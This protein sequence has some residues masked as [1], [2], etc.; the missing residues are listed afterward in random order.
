M[1]FHRS[2]AASVEKLGQREAG[3]R[4]LHSDLPSYVQSVPR[5]SRREKT[6][7]CHPHPITLSCPWAAVALL[8]NESHSSS[9]CGQHCRNVSDRKE[10]LGRGGVGEKR[11]GKAWREGRGLH[12]CIK[13][14][15][16]LNTM[17]APGR[18]LELKGRQNKT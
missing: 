13:G 7:P 5:D 18:D 2:Q 12:R 9:I 16:P 10:G 14:Q 17:G 3:P 8:Q 15:W 1:C 4:S 6:C 11:K